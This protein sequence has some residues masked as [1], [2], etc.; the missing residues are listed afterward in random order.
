VSGRS[1]G[2]FF[3]YSGKF[4]HIIIIVK[5]SNIEIGCGGIG[6]F[7]ISAA[8]GIRTF[9]GHGNIQ[10]CHI[11]MCSAL[12]AVVLETDHLLYLVL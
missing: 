2:P 3:Y 8:V 4:P 10:Y 9:I 7:I 6:V 5:Y 12:C 11:E 1:R